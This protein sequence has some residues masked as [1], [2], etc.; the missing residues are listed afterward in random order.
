MFAILI[1]SDS[2]VSKR[3]EIDFVVNTKVGFLFEA[4]LPNS[5]FWDAT[6][7]TL[8]VYDKALS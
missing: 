3:T 6:I 8:S 1:F 4:L 2:L 5:Y 7:L